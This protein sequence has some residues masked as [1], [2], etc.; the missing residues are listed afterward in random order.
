MPVI[1][2]LFDQRGKRSVRLQGVRAQHGV[3][4]TGADQQAE[5]AVNA[6][7]FL[8]AVEMIHF[9]AQ[10]IHAVSSQRFGTPR[11]RRAVVLVAQPV[12]HPVL[13]VSEDPIGS[14]EDPFA[15]ETDQLAGGKPDDQVKGGMQR[16]QELPILM[17]HANIVVRQADDQRT[18]F[19]LNPA[20]LNA[21]HQFRLARFGI[22]T[23]EAHAVHQ[24]KGRVLPEGVQAAVG[25]RL[26]GEIHGQHAGASFHQDAGGALLLIAFDGIGQSVKTPGVLHPV[27]QINDIPDLRMGEVVN[28]VDKIQRELRIHRFLPALVIVDRERLPFHRHRGILRRASLSRSTQRSGACRKQAIQPQAFS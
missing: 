10:L 11:R 21:L 14:E 9:H 5:E 22:E 15:V 3:I 28:A 18:A 23:A 13:R 12:N 6:V 7:A 26:S 20:A 25:H 16:Q 4:Q 17:D 1:Q 8:Q 19:P 24:R 27:S 2:V